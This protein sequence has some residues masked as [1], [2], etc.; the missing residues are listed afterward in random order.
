[1]GLRPNR[2]IESCAAMTLAAAALTVALCNGRAD[3]GALAVWHGMLRELLAGTTEGR[4]ALVG[5]CWFGPLPTLAASCCAWLVGQSHAALVALALTA[6]CGWACALHRAGRLTEGT[7]AVRLATQAT[8]AIVLSACGGALNPAVA[9]PVWL[10]LI[11][12]GAAASWTTHAGL[13]A[14]VTLGFA[15]GAMGLCGV[16]LAGW[17]LVP[18]LGL[19]LATCRHSTVRGRL[20]AVLLLGWLPVVYALAVWALLDWLLLGNPLYFVHPLAAAGV[21]A[22]RGWVPE[23]TT[24]M[25]LTTVP[26]AVA[27]LLALIRRRADDA[28]L[29]GLALAAWIWMELVRAASASWVADAAG[30]LALLLGI[31]ALVRGARRITRRGG[32]LTAGL[33]AVLFAAVIWQPGRRSAPRVESVTV[34][35]ARNAAL[36]QAVEA[37]VRARTPY[38]RVFVCGYEGLALLHDQPRGRLLPNLDLHVGELRRLY[39]GQTLFILVHRPIGRAAADSVHWRFPDSYRLGLERTLY[40]RD[41]GE[42]WR[43][44]KVVGAPTEEQ[45][46]AWRK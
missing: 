36:C 44:F 8:A 2:V 39:Y 45:L 7:L 34:P 6:W 31:A 43:L 35:Q 1:M 29:G 21:L 46:R 20:P 26:A 10:G 40:A 28:V 15:L 9:L 18:M 33:L 13:R 41:F 16:S 30:P 23:P 24:M 22:W 37:D 4:Q 32:V 17:A 42:E 12:A 11:A 3:S 19:P 38:G 25:V 14:L 5:S 27:L